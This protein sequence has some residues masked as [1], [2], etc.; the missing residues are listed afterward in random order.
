MYRE[1]N[2]PATSMKNQIFRADVP[3][4]LLFSLLD[5]LCMKTEKYYYIEYTSFRKFMFDEEARDAW[6]TS[7]RPYYH[8]SKRYYLDRK[9]TYNG[10]I[11][12][13]RQICKKNH[14]PFT[15]KIHYNKT[16]YNIDYYIFFNG[17]ETNTKQ[18]IT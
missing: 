15:S 17:F 5:R 1:R 9:M 3:N 2:S 7:L 6:L 11:N 14:I 12:L 18:E 13:V 8:E 4:A 16:S 10:F